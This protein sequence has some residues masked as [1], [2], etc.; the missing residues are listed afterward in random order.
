MST[1]FVTGATGSIG[2]QIIPMLAEKH[3]VVALVRSPNHPHVK[4]VK[5]I[6]GYLN[7]PESYLPHMRE[8]DVLIH[9][10]ASVR[11]DSADLDR[12]NVSA[13]RD[14][15]LS[16]RQQGIRNIIIF[17]SASVTKKYFTPYSRSKQKMETMLNELNIPMI[18]LRPTL[19]YSEKSKYISN[20]G[21]FSRLPLPFIP[22]PDGDLA[23][24][25]PVYAPDI[26]KSILA[27][28][29][30]P[31]PSHIVTYDL[32]PT[33]PFTFE[34]AIRAIAAKNGISKP[35]VNVSHALF[36]E[37]YSAL[38]EPSGKPWVGIGQLGAAGASNVVDSTP[39]TKKYGV[40]FTP[41]K[42]QFPQCIV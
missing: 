15:V 3:E 34:D 20:I 19:T 37:L 28:L 30:Q 11:N 29:S 40:H 8:C 39:F 36:G 41:A 14:I 6:M 9:M 7:R 12:S 35:I 17:S 13:T 26:G 27:I 10:A 38:N 1:L 18:I 23:D 21:K 22:L 32:C 5:W 24:L 16:A 31:F 2:S 25:R 42:T 4:N 33:E